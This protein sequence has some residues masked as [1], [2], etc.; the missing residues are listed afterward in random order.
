M[1]ESD[2]AF[3]SASYR[4][5][6]LTFAFMIFPY[7]ISVQLKLDFLLDTPIVISSG[8]DSEQSQSNIKYFH[9]LSLIQ[10]LCRFSL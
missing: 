3:F 4:I 10:P 9:Q 8:G 6:M 7:W 5:S 2:E 1:R